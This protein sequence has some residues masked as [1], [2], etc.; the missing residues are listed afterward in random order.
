MHDLPARACRIFESHAGKSVEGC[1]FALVSRIPPAMQNP[2]KLVKV[3]SVTKARERDELGE[4]VTAWIA[5]NP[6]L[7]I[8]RTF[9]ALTSD[10]KF[11]CLSMVLVCAAA[12]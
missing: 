2:L 8:L 7:K 10:N 3:F 12:S 6:G 4:R 9:I 1:G 5:A 11:H